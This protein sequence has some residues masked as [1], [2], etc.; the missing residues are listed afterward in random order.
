MWFIK[1]FIKLIDTGNNNEIVL[2]IIQYKYKYIV[3]VKLKNFIS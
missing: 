1:S 2:Y 3:S